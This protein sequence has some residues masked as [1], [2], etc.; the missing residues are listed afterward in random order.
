MKMNVYAAIR[1]GEGKK[2]RG[3]VCDD[4]VL[5]NGMVMADGYYEGEVE[6]GA[7][8]AVADGVGGCGCGFKAAEVALNEMSSWDYRQ[9]EDETDLRAAFSRVND[10]VMEISR[11][12]LEYKGTKST[13]SAVIVN[14]SNV[15]MLHVGDS[16]IY[17]LREVQEYRLFR[18]LTKDQNNLLKWQTDNK[19]DNVYVDDDE[20]KRQPDWSY[21]TSFV[22]MES[23]RFDKMMVTMDDIIGDGTFVLTSDGIHDFVDSDTLEEIL[24]EELSYKEKLDK[25]MDV[26]KTNGSHDDRSIIILEL[27]G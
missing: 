2:D 5:V 12:I 13:L 10:R 24:C 3:M 14:D 22:G 25:L 9:F 26:A 23:Q 16:R 20:L 6:E 17:Q 21:I 15:S 18:Q 1:L 8:V 19:K 27:L 11:N 4:R 7:I